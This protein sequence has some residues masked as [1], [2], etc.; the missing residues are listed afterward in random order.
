MNSVDRSVV[1]FNNFFLPTTAS[2]QRIISLI[3]LHECI[4]VYCKSNLPTCACDMCTRGAQSRVVD[5]CC[6]IILRDEIAFRA[7]VFSKETKLL[8][9]NI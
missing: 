2:T 5:I 6:A 9:E 7:S 4:T 3:H 1:I 8:V